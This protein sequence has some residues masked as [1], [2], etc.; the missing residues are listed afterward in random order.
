M[1]GKMS[2]VK[3][4]LVTGATGVIGQHL[5]ADLVSEKKKVLALGD[6]A[7]A[8]SPDVLQNKAIRVNTALPV[9]PES[10]KHHDVQF[11]FGDIGDISFLASVFATVVKSGIEIEYVF[12][13]TAN[14]VIQKTSPA[15]FHPGFSAAA[16]VLE[17]VRA[18]AQ[19]HKE[20]FKG[21]FFAS[22]TDKKTAEKTAA[23]VAKIAQKDGFPAIVFDGEDDDSVIGEGYH[24]KTSLE[25]LY[26]VASPF[27]LPQTIQPKNETPTTERSYIKKLL[28]AVHHIIKS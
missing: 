19:S 26:R 24:G 15:A 27:V 11:C 10:F 4:C 28:R 14:E 20:T 1:E 23:L 9:T 3:V 21:L 18:Y 22:E 2:T 5:L 8:F 16:N 12:H 13:L 25:S 6:P 7:D 17:V